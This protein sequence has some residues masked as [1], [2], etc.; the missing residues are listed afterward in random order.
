MRVLAERLF[1]DARQ[2]VAKMG[3]PLE[4]VDVDVAL[5]GERA[6]MS[7]LRQRECDY[8][9]FV[10]ALSRKH[11]VLLIMQNLTL[12]LA[13]TAE[14]HGCGRPDCGQ[15]NGGCGSCATG[16]CSLGGCAAG[17]KKEDIASYLANLALPGQELPR[18]PLL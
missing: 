12:P 2:L 9:E 11:N 18:T 6:T 1:L 5:D 17:S 16:G 7:H 15:G 10:S 13:A 4:I 3:L 8:R 14:E